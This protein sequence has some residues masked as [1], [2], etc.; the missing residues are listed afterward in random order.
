MP[1]I[2]NSTARVAETASFCYQ[3]PLTACNARKILVKPNLGYPVGP[4]ATVSMAVLQQVLTGL[5]QVSPEAEILIVEGVCSKVSFA[6]IMGQ[7]G[8]YL[9]LDEGMQILDADTLALAE[10][11]NLAPSP[12]RF[13]SLWAP[14][15]LQTVDCR[16]S[17][18]AFKRTTLKGRSLISAAL[19]N[20]YGLFPRAHYRARS[21][22]SRGQLHRPS[23]P[24]VLQDVYF[25]I[26]HLFEGAVVDCD[27]KFVSRD[28]RPDRGDAVAIGH[29]IWGDDI[30]A[31]DSL[32]CEIGGE[33]IPAYL[34]TIRQQRDSSP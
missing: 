3:P 12:V 14:R 13:H 17:V 9:L 1:A 21:A 22:S 18:G 24:Q 23:V 19:K 15:L 20:L 28:W 8:L 26:G 16:I 5:R 2:T 25:T 34:K 32:A 10:Y 11:P 4:P 7:L 6:D 30:L 33:P 31:V 27:Q 29:V